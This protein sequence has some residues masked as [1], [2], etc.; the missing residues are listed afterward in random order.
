SGVDG[1]APLRAF[2]RGLGGLRNMYRRSAGVVI[3]YGWALFL[4]AG[5]AL[6]GVW[7]LVQGL[8]NEFL[9][10]VDD[11]GVSVGINLPPGSLPEQRNR[12]SLEIEQLIREM[13]DVEHMFA[14]AGGRG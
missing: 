2:D 13:P 14:S 1:W 12:I 11:G 3:R 7:R 9:P 10:Q 8:P 6:F 5:L 4:V